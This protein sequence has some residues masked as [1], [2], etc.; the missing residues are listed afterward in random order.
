M[1]RKELE[2]RVVYGNNAWARSGSLGGCSREILN[3]LDL[4]TQTNVEHNKGGGVVDGKQ[5]AAT[6]P[7][8][9][10]NSLGYPVYMTPRHG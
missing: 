1:C 3:S 10:K 4:I 7:S 2:E 8:P 9:K 6:S 5:Y